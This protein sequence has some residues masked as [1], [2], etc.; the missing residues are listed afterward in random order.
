MSAGLAL[1]LMTETIPACTG[2]MDGLKAQ[3]SQ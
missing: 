3:L 2:E 1:A